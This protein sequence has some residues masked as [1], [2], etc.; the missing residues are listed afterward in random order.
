VNRIKTL[1]LKHLRSEL[2]EPEQQELDAW[3]SADPGNQALFD[4][5]NDPTRVGEVLAKMDAVDEEGAFAR[6]QLA[7]AAQ[8]NELTPETKN[9]LPRFLLAAALILILAGATILTIKSLNHH[10]PAV[11]TTPILKHDAAPGT[12]KAILTLSTGHQILL[13]SLNQDTIL[14]EGAS[15]VAGKRGILAYN[16]GNDA[17]VAI[18]YNT[19]TTPRGGQYQLTLPD[20]TH[21]WLNAAS[22]ITYPTAF[23]ED[24][25]VVKITGEAYFEVAHDPGHGFRILTPT[26]AVQDIG[27]SFNVNSY[28]DETD[29]TATVLTGKVKFIPAPASFAQHAPTLASHTVMLLS[30]GEQARMGPQGTL[31]GVDHPDLTQALAWKNGLFAFTNADLPTVMRQLSRWYNVDV[32]YEGTIPKDKYEFNGKIGKTLTLDQVLKILTR[33]QVNYTIEGNQLTIKP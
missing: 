7:T 2:S 31:T 15:V 8:T 17:S 24:E 32:K 26:A 13:D 6:V 28:S 14:T 18:T 25:R 21:V 22:S 29:V 4:E 10:T 9:R 16:P 5:I 30:A 12:A 33:T 27:T 3:L 11:A 1:I 19:L 20:G 23:T